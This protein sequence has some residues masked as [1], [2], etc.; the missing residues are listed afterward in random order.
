MEIGTRRATTLDAEA[1]GQV[2]W[3]DGERVFCKLIRDDGRGEL[4]AFIPAGDAPTPQTIERLTHEGSLKHHLD[5]S[6]ALR[7]LELVRERG[8]TML[9]VDYAGGEPLDRL[10][11]GP[12]DVARFLRLAIG[13]STAVGRLHA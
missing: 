12:M 11:D 7:P 9:I 6:W 10:I 8:R 3:R 1:I 4:H 2:L 13:I 5:A